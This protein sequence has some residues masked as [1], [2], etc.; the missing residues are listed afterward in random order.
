MELANCKHCGGLFLMNKSG[1]CSRCQTTH[2]RIYMRVRDDLRVHPKSTVMD[3]H[4]RTGI[5]VSK[6]LEIRREDYIP[7]SR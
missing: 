6:L 7:F 1:Y 5:P 2:D 3:V 4:V